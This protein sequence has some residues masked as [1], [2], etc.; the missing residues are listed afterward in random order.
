MTEKNFDEI[1]DPDENIAA[2]QEAMGQPIQEEVMTLELLNKRRVKVRYIPQSITSSL[3]FDD[4]TPVTPPGTRKPKFQYRR[5]AKEVL[6]KMNALALQ[7]V[8]IVDDLDEKVALGPKAIRLSLISLGEFRRLQDLCFPGSANNSPD[9]EDEDNVPRG[10]GRK[11]IRGGK[12]D[13]AGT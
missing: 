5:W 8:E 12:P 4:G 13:Q 11:S 1:I 10:K 9:L 6:P 7:N 2:L 3:E